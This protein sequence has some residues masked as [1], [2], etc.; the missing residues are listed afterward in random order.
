MANQRMS[1]RCKA[2][3]DEKFIAKHVMAAFHTVR[4]DGWQ[5]EWDIWFEEHEWGF[6]DPEQRQW[7]L[8]C[9]ELVYE[10]TNAEG[11]PESA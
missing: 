3:G 1:L 2:C 8:E 4:K 11:N 10:H 5:E 7:G 6:C 9:F